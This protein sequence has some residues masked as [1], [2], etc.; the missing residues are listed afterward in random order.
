[1]ATNGGIEY[2]FTADAEMPRCRRS[3]ASQTTLT[4]PPTLV[5]GYTGATGLAVDP[6]NKFVYTANNLNGTVGQAT[7]KGRAAARYARVRWCR[8]RARPTPTA[9]RG[10]SRWRS[11]ARWTPVSEAG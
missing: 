4:V 3:L 7:I 10:G 8:P 6:Q 1:M 5:T 2:L 11:D 9:V